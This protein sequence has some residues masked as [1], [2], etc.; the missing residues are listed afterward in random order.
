MNLWSVSWCVF[1]NCACALKG[2]I[3]RD[4]F[5]FRSAHEY[6]NPV[7]NR[8]PANSSY[9]LADLLH[10]WWGLERRIHK[11][12]NNFQSKLPFLWIDDLH[13]GWRQSHVHALAECHCQVPVKTFAW[14]LD[15]LRSSNVTGSNGQAIAKEPRPLCGLSGE[16][17]GVVLRMPTSSPHWLG[18]ADCGVNTHL[19]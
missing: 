2:R 16:T 1:I 4:F 7:C 12:L 18:T 14:K 8:Y 15:L 17:T 10:M 3:V 19:F 5:C 11:E 13:N 6:S 9:S